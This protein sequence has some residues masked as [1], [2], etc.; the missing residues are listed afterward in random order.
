MYRI[1]NSLM[2]KE[3]IQIN[4]GH[5]I[6]RKHV[7]FSK[8]QVDE[9][10]QIPIRLGQIS[11]PH[12][13]PHALQSVRCQKASFKRRFAVLASVL[14]GLWFCLSAN[15]SQSV[16]LAWNPSSDSSTAGY[17]VYA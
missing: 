10:T 4:P 1:K 5:V 3:T 8:W 16:S 11:I 17:V 13:S 6:Q 7:S 2:N 14:L 15:A 12:R 9:A